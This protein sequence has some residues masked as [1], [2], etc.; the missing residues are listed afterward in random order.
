MGRKRR[1]ISAVAMRI[2]SAGLPEASGSTTA[3]CA[4]PAYTSA[5]IKTISSQE[6]PNPFAAIPS[7]ND[8]GMKAIQTGT[9]AL[10]PWRNAAVKNGIPIQLAESHRNIKL[11]CA[12]GGEI[13][14]YAQNDIKRVLSS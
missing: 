12:F 4:G 11:G 2:C 9:A 3:Y 8:D 5:D 14:R 7:A 13:L 6:R 1:F 10:T